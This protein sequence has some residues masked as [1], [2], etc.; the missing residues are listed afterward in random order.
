MAH[1]HHRALAKLRA[2]LGLLPERNRPTF[3]VLD[4]FKRVFR[5]TIN[6]KTY[7]NPPGF[8]WTTYSGPYKSY[9]GIDLDFGQSAA[10]EADINMSNM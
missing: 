8:D 3:V 7:I 6:G 1:R 2:K 4:Y 5:V 10:G 9:G